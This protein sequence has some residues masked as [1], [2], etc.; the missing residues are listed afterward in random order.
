M[1]LRQ[2][3]AWAGVLWGERQSVRTQPRNG[4]VHMRQ[5]RAQ[6]R[7]AIEALAIVCRQPETGLD[8]PLYLPAGPETGEI[9]LFVHA[10]GRARQGPND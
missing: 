10:L 8:L 3:Q 1:S 5:L 7:A 9:D 6:D 4:L 2:R